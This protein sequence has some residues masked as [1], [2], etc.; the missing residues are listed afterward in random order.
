MNQEKA[1]FF[2]GQAGSAWA[3]AEYGSADREK[4]EWLFENIGLRP[5]MWVLEP[6]C[7]TGRLTTILAER[8]GAAGRV[9]ALDISPAMI[10]R[11]R[12]RTALFPNVSVHL[13]DLEGT[14]LMPG[15][16]DLVLCFN[17]FPHFDDPIEALKTCRR[18]LKP[19][20][21]LAVF[22]LEPS[23][24]INDLHRKSGPVKNDMIPGEGELRRMGEITGFRLTSF[25]DDDRFLARMERRD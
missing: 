9:T 14:D 20:G 22:H 19:S 16:F 13:A 18:V 5:G 17:T 12:K 23:A 10:D 3:D 6:G 1:E 4:I 25:R 15:S 8:V 7:G 2:D 24:V 21:G 11:C